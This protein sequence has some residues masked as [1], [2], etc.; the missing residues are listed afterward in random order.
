MAIGNIHSGTI[1]GKLNGVIPAQT[2]SGCIRL[3]LST[4]RPTFIECSPF[5]KC[6]IPQ[7]NSTTSKPRVSSPWASE[8]TLPC[9]LLISTASS[10]R[11]CSSKALNLNITRARFNGVTCDQLIKAVA[12]AA[13]AAR[14]SSAV[15]KLTSVWATPVAGSNT[16]WLR[17][18]WLTTA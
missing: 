6:G 15:A 9:S 18:L 10:S 3:K 1:A 4:P 2:P 12:A 5:N 13:M 8:N 11:C 17:P 16:G 7:A 14:V